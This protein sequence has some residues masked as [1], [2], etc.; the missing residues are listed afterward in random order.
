MIRGSDV[1]KPHEMERHAR[2][3][4]S[5]TAH[6]VGAMACSAPSLS[7]SHNVVVFQATRRSSNCL[8]RTDH[9]GALFSFLSFRLYELSSL[10]K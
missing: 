5:R 10:L 6:T 4:R 1:Q 3:H 9:V 7:S 2:R 8:V